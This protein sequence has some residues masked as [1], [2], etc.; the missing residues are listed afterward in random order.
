MAFP[1]YNT[2]NTRLTATEINLLAALTGWCVV[3][4]DQGSKVFSGLFA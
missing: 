2:V 4:A 3:S 1:H